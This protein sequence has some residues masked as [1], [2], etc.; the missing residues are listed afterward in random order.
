MCKR[1]TINLSNIFRIPFSFA[2]VYSQDEKK[3][4]SD[5]RFNL[6]VGLWSNKNNQTTH[7]STLTAP[8][9]TRIT[10][11][12]HDSR[13]GGCAACGKYLLWTKL[14]CC[15]WKTKISLMTSHQL[16]HCMS[17]SVSGIPCR[18]D[19]NTTAGNSQRPEG[20]T[21]GECSKVVVWNVPN[22]RKWLVITKLHHLVN[23]LVHFKERILV[24]CGTADPGRRSDGPSGLSPLGRDAWWN[25]WTPEWRERHPG[26]QRQIH[27]KYTEW[28]F[29]KHVTC[30]NCTWRSTETA[31]HS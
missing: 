8:A 17:V 18:G 13:G 23:I 24:C 25:G 11:Y 2:S 22:R 14:C 15:S 1:T 30:K 19:S 31:Q 26:V 27:M 9:E 20:G 4:P 10:S 5:I 6:Y 21:K 12:R 29:D 28:Y 3:T 7:K 16:I